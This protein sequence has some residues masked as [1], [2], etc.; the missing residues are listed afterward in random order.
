MTPLDASLLPRLVRYDPDTGAFTWLPREAVT[1]KHKSWNTLR[2]GKPAFDT[3]EP[4]NGYLRGTVLG[5][6]LYA[7]RT[8]F[9]FIHGRWPAG[10]I[11]HINGI[12]TDN[13][14][15][16]LREVSRAENCRN[17]RIDP[18]TPD[19]VMGIFKS[20]GKWQAQIG[21]GGKTR[22]IG[23]Y[24]TKDEAVAARRRAEAELGF[25]PNHGLASSEC[26]L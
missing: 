14:A 16:N 25:H 21:Y 5:R 22:Y 20:F 11:D 6:R 12:R 8:A 24:A 4:S 17:R 2:A 7:H 19:G 9:A 23:R 15:V 26:R 10:D 13:R 3:F 18:R 1:A